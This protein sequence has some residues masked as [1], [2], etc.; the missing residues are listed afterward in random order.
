MVDYPQKEEKRYYFRRGQI[1]MLVLGFTVTAAFIYFLGLLTGVQMTVKTEGAPARISVEP[2]GQATDS[3]PGAPLEPG[4]ASHI[5]LPKSST[6]R[7][8]KQDQLQE[9][10]QLEQVAKVEIKPMAP[11][12]KKSKSTAEAKSIQKADEKTGALWPQQDEA[13]A[14]ESVMPKKTAK[15]WTVQ[16]NSFPDEASAVAWEYALK[17]KGYDAYTMKAVVKEKSW[18]RVRVGHLANQNEADALRK[19]IISKEGF[20]DAFLARQQETDVIISAVKKH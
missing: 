18:Y 9:N 1:V 14:S 16:V 13:H 2:L 8:P 20:R 4:L 15:I 7:P 19:L 11:H 5:E 10:K 12:D 17:T 3:A 6:S